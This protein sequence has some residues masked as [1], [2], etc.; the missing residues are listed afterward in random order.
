[1]IELGFK[2]L[3][4]SLERPS[5]FPDFDSFRRGL[6][7][8]AV[9]IMNERALDRDDCATLARLGDPGEWVQRV[10]TNNRE[11]CWQGDDTGGVPASLRKPVTDQGWYVVLRDGGLE[12]VRKIVKAYLGLFPDAPR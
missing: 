7:S 1:M 10:L 9:A 11:L 12:P 5:T 3:A 8:H 6:F 4:I 2:P